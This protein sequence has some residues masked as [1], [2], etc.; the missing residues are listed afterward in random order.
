[1]NRWPAFICL[2]ALS[3][4]LVGRPGDSP[5]RPGEAE[6]CPLPVTSE[7]HSAVDAKSS[8]L[9]SL[10]LCQVVMDEASFDSGWA[11]LVLTCLDLWS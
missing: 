5:S 4:A 8:L 6:S 3:R 11:G 7:V 2:F 10:L 9:V 1:M